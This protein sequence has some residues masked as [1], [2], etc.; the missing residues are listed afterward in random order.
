MTMLE[1]TDT[2]YA[3]RIT[4]SMDD[5]PEAVGV[6]GPRNA[7]EDLCALLDQDK[8][9]KGRTFA[10]KLFD[11]DGEWYYSGRLALPEGVTPWTADEVAAFGPLT[12]WGAP[13]AGATELRYRTPAGAWETM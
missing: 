10:F 6:T 11:D 2:P 7:P 9:V 4:K 3:W 5:E 8:P 13:N 1:I 12:D